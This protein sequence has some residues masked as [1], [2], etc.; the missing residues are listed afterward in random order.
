MIDRSLNY[1]RHHISRFLRQAGEAAAIVDL[2]AGKGADLAAARLVYPQAALYG[3]ESW[4]PY[5]ETL[6]AQGISVCQLNIEHAPLPF[7]DQ[8]VDI[9]IAN[10][11]L[12]HCKE[13]FWIFS[14]VSR[15]LKP[16]GCFIV[17]VPNL[18]ALHNRI[19]L[20]CGRQ[21]SPIKT[22]S[23][24]IR[25]FTRSD[26]E[27]FLTSCWPGGYK[28]EGFGGANFYPFPPL[29]ARPLAALL[30]NLAWGIFLLLRKV[31]PYQGEFRKFPAAEQLETNFYTGPSGLDAAAGDDF[32]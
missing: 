29:L 23:A 12:E 2:G 25:G 30:P 4:T 13:I 16:G 8:S 9:F 5:V 3:V 28:I 15:V 24:H 20:A 10:Q 17:G 21:P 26:L 6:S 11:V 1:G 31:K 14:E 18:A 27:H 22:A 19:L 32:S 7:A